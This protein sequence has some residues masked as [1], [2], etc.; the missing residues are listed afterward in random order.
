MV[1]SRPN[2]EMGNDCRS[3]LT[4]IAPYKRETSA[5]PS[6]GHRLRTRSRAKYRRDRAVHRSF[7]S[8][9][10]MECHCRLTMETSLEVLKKTAKP[11]NQKSGKLLLSIDRERFTLSY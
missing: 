5:M 10:Q 7:R 4:R 2:R 9:R 6:A 8:R 1:A 3:G 11:R